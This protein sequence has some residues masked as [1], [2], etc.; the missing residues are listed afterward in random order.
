MSGKVPYHY[1]S[2][3]GVFHAVSKGIRPR[4]PVTPLVTDA[5]WKFIHL[6]W[7]QTQSAR[8]CVRE[9]ND[10]VA[11]L[12]HE[13]M[14]PSP[15]VQQEL[16]QIPFPVANRHLRT[17]IPSIDGY[18]TDSESLRVLSPQTQA[19]GF[20]SEQEGGTMRKRAANK[21]RIIRSR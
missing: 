7:H 6:C 20:Q 19:S 21:S 2:E 14:N 17:I 9:V 11:A 5:L 13:Y 18:E 10:R 1:L 16:V 8:P 4:R 12:R 15:N 3:L